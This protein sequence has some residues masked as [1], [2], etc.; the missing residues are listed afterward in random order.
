MAP[1]VVR[2]QPRRE[3][4]RSRVGVCSSYFTMP[5]ARAKRQR[6]ECT[7]LAELARKQKLKEARKQAKAK[8]R[9]AD[10]RKAAREG[11]HDISLVYNNAAGVP[12][13][14]SLDH[15]MAG[16]HS[17]KPENYQLRHDNHL[18][19]V[20]DALAR[21]EFF[22]DVT[23]T[24]EGHSLKAHKSVLSA[25]SPYFRGVL[26]DNP[27]QHPV[28]IMPRDVRFEELSSIVNYIY[29]GETTVAAE[30]LISF[31][32]TAKILQISGLAQH[33]FSANVNPHVDCSAAGDARSSSSASSNLPSVSGTSRLVTTTTTDQ[34]ETP[35]ARPKSRESMI[36]LTDCIDVDMPYVKEEV[37]NANEENKQIFRE[38]SLHTPEVVGNGDQE[39]QQSSSALSPSHD[40]GLEQPVVSTSSTPPSPLPIN[41]DSETCIDS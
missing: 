2:K 23:L 36:S 13:A 39:L 18:T 32:K 41:S 30:D 38:S 8:K 34:M 7:I 3:L 24:A 12:V 20:L 9:Q 31:M 4:R 10:M 27:C 6:R 5:A 17:H 33:D 40:A 11:R 14:V 19:F 25:V 26:R 21:D 16:K 35:P 37:E 28:I 22:M 29:K 1:P 15:F